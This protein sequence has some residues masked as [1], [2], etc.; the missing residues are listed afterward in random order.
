MGQ[1]DRDLE[2]N[3]SPCSKSELAELSSA[4][5]PVGTFS[6]WAESQEMPPDS[7]AGG[8]KSRA[9]AEGLEQ[10]VHADALA[11]VSTELEES[12]TPLS[13]G[14]QTT[15]ALHG[16]RVTSV[17]APHSPSH[18][19][20]CDYTAAPLKTSSGMLSVDIVSVGLPPSLADGIF[21]VPQRV[22][23]CSDTLDA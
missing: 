18:N 14:A 5:Q 22:V 21:Y 12:S 1:T 9:V 20:N 8:S 17:P 4:D 7:P 23:R 10:E 15:S 3:V 19:F 13:T 2:C 11:D 6:W 16:S